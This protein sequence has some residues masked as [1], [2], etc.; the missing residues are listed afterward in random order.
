MKEQKLV[1]IHHYHNL[2]SLMDSLQEANHKC[3]ED[4][5]HCCVDVAVEVKIRALNVLG[6]RLLQ[7]EKS[8]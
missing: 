2:D 5:F 8:F 1:K 4:N 3:M 6:I 7:Q